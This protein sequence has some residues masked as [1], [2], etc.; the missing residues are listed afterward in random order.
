MSDFSLLASLLLQ[1]PPSLFLPVPSQ[2]ET[3]ASLSWVILSLVLLIQAVVH[4]AGLILS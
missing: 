1:F 2:L 3:N 4:S